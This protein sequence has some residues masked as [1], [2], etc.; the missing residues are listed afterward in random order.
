MYERSLNDIGKWIAI[1]S[2]IIGTILL[3]CF[4]FFDNDNIFLIGYLYILFAI[5]VNLIIL[6]FLVINNSKGK[7]LKTIGLIL[8]NIPI[9][10][11]YFYIVIFLLNTL[12]ITLINNTGQTL[13]E[14]NILGCENKNIIQLAKNE[15]RTIWVNI[16]NDCSVQIEFDIEGKTKTQEVIGYATNLGGGKHQFKIEN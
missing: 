9:A 8:L 3:L 2:F 1:F 5:I 13:N 10:Y 7:N 16:P 4:Y 14:V 15:R 12:R 11:F 6:I